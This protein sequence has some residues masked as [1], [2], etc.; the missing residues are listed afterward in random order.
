MPKS[1]KSSKK[2]SNLTSV[3]STISGTSKTSDI[4]I[5]IIDMQKNLNKEIKIDYE[6]ERRKEEEEKKREELLKQQNY[7]NEISKLE[8]EL[9]TKLPT[10]G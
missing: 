6:E 2:S 9:N 5:P 7:L 8:E 1:K 10:P 4:K 3:T